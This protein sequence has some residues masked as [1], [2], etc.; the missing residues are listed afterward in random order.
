MEKPGVVD[1]ELDA[2]ILGLS[3]DGLKESL[4]PKM[5]KDEAEKEI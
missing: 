2:N 1:E 3:K 5:D 4:I